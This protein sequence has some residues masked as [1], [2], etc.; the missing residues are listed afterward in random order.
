MTSIATLNFCPKKVFWGDMKLGGDKKPSF[1]IMDIIRSMIKEKGFDAFSDAYKTYRHLQETVPE[2][3]YTMSKEREV[4]LVNCADRLSRMHSILLVNGFQFAGPGGRWSWQGE[5]KTIT[6][7]YDAVMVRDGIKYGLKLVSTTDLSVRPKT[8]HC[9]SEDPDLYFMYKTTGLMPAV[10][11]LRGKT[12]A[13]YDAPQKVDPSNEKEWNGRYLFLADYSNGTDGAEEKLAD[14]LKVQVSRTAFENKANCARCDY[15]ALCQ[16]Q[17]PDDA[18]MPEVVQKPA[19]AAKAPNWTPTQKQLI[20]FDEG[21]LRVLAGAGSGK[22]ST[23]T[24]RMAR[25]IQDGTVP[26]QILAVT[27][28]EKAVREMQERLARFAGEA[29]AARVKVTTFNGLGFD[30]LKQH[31]NRMF[32][33]EPEL[34]DDSE[35]LRLIAG[36]LDKEPEIKGLNYATPWFRMFRALG[37]VH[38]MSLILAKV[39]RTNAGGKTSLSEVKAALADEIAKH[40]WR[41]SD[42]QSVVTI[43]NELYAYEQS[44]ALLEYD[45]QI[46]LAV[47]L[48]EENPD[49]RKGYQERFSHIIIDEFQDTGLDQMKMVEMIYAPGKGK[50]L[51]VCGDD[52]QSIYGFRGVGNE[53]IL[54]FDSVYPNSSTITMVENFRS[55]RQILDLSNRVISLNGVTKKLVGIK[56]GEKPK[57]VEAPSKDDAAREAF[58]QVVDWINDGTPMHDIAVLAKSRAEVLAVRE[59]LQMAG[60]PTVVSVAEFLKDDVQV[61]GAEALAKWIQKPEEM[62]F[63]AIWLRHANMEEFDANF[64]IASYL[65]L[66]AMELQ[67]RFANLSD[68]ALYDEFMQVL[69]ETFASKGREYSRPMKTWLAMEEKE[70]NSFARM[71]A[72]LQDIVEAGSSLSAEADDTVYEAVTLST[73]HAA[74][75]REWEKVIVLPNGLDSAPMKTDLAGI[76]RLEF[77][78][79]EIRTYFVAITRAREDLVIIGNA[80]WLAPAR[81]ISLLTLETLRNLRIPVEDPFKKERDKAKRKAAK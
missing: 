80:Y 4:N 6:G 81:G 36:F 44:Q 76:V 38:E 29:A 22:T 52:A 13:E 53:N 16:V 26:E 67:A 72:S 61:V 1:T 31:W 42:L 27:F 78:E 55:T 49:I 41:D 18:V 51:M 19:G 24:S 66:K 10:Y 33:K 28:T 63:L 39:K 68:T 20:A 58:M 14:A 57:L 21:E 56:D 75:G 23:L 15:R 7:T 2:D 46:H 60:I 8:Q 40:E 30:L 34:I 47:R 64:D 12:E 74:K 65:A 48:L 54:N 62:R 17:N 35:K 37:A 11:S 71:S 59:Q 70:D 32:Q 3:A 9:V 69:S 77:G 5:G 43:Y 50:S 73:I 79:E 25:L 45:D